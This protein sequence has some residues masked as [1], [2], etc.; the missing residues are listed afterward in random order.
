MWDVHGDSIGNM[1]VLHTT[2]DDA[3]VAAVDAKTNLVHALFLERVLEELE[4]VQEVVVVLGSGQEAG[5]GVWWT[6]GETSLQRTTLRSRTPPPTHHSQH[7]YA[8]P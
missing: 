1:P 7:T 3:S 4:V 2:A 8:V 5:G 6:G